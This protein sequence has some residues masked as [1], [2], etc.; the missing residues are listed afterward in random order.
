M[1]AAP[2]AGSSSSSSSSSSAF[3]AFSPEVV[4]D[5]F[6]RKIES[7]A[8]WRDQLLAGLSDGSLLLLQRPPSAP[9]AAPAAGAGA[10]PRAW[11]VSRVHKQLSKRPLL[12]LLA[13][14]ADSLL[15]ALSG[16]RGGGRGTAR[17]MLPPLL[18]APVWMRLGCL[19]THAA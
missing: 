10:P 7:L 12:Q 8:V 15:L 9:S 6:G 3:Q 19:H 1:A 17:V 2:A 14:E 16:R 11:Q 18:P 13:L 4:V 5:D